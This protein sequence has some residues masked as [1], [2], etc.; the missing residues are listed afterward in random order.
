MN[1]L[2]EE[3]KIFIFAAAYSLLLY[4][5]SFSLWEIPLDTLKRVRTGSCGTVKIIFLMDP[6]EGLRPPQWPLATP[7]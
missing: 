1:V 5:M 4:H 3:E 7:G 6:L 2:I